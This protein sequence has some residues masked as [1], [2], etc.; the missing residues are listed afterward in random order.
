MCLHLET[1]RS[2]QC[3]DSHSFQLMHSRLHCSIACSI[4]WGGGEEGEGRRG[5]GEEGRRGG[6]EEG[7]RGG[8]EE[9]R[10]GGRGEG[11]RGEGGRGEGGRGKGG[12]GEGGR[13]VISFT[14]TN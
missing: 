5:G 2:A 1:R 6:G 4:W 8:G 13:G 10:R 9:G 14:N 3:K 7:R 11:G 12:R